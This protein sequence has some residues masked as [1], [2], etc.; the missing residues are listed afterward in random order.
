MICRI[1]F[2]VEYRI[3]RKAELKAY[4]DPYTDASVKVASDGGHVIQ[5]EDNDV[6]ALVAAHARTKAMNCNLGL[7]QQPIYPI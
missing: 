2:T 3:R 7:T 4:C 6:N 1:R 5:H